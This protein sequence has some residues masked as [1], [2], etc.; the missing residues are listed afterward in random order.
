MCGGEGLHCL[1]FCGK[2]QFFSHGA[3]HFL[4]IGAE[5]KAQIIGLS[6]S[7][8]VT[9]QFPVSVMLSCNL[10]RVTEKTQVSFCV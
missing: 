6:Y 10:H 3:L 8:S 7:I 5:T 4:S 2:S 9:W 1:E